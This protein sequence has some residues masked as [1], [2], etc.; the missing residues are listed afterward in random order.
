MS[1]LE[2]EVTVDRGKDGGAMRVLDESDRGE[3]ARVVR[4]LVGAIPNPVRTVEDASAS[5]L[6]RMFPTLDEAGR[7]T[8]TTE[9]PERVCPVL[10]TD[11]VFYKNGERVDHRRCYY[12]ESVVEFDRVE[13]H[14]C[15]DWTLELG[16]PM[17]LC[18]AGR[19]DMLLGRHAR[20]ASGYFRTFREQGGCTWGRYFPHWETDSL[21]KQAGLI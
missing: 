19:F 12:V 1:A 9:Q 11:L 6:P 5:Y 17:P 2:I 7:W 21:H 15:H 18:E 14:V 10:D 4:E 3:I 16:T 20:E 13:V 8:I